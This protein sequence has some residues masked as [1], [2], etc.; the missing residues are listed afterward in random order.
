MILFL[1]FGKYFMVNKSISGQIEKL[2]AKKFR[3]L[4]ADIA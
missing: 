2:F 3:M 1:I 4:G